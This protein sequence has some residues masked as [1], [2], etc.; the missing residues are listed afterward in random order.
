MVK[1]RV[2]ISQVSDGCRLVFDLLDRRQ[3]S[4]ERDRCRKKNHDGRCDSITMITI[5]LAISLASR[6]ESVD[7]IELNHIYDRKGQ[8][9]FDQVVFWER[10]PATGRFQVRAW[11]MVDDREELNR[12]P[13]K[14]EETGR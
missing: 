2:A 6:I 5:V 9:S 11:C 13:V 1:N 7:L 12:R 10:S 8:L 3:C 14:S 4:G